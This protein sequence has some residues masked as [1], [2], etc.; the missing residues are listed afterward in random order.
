MRKVLGWAALLAVVALAQPGVAQAPAALPPAASADEAF[1]ARMNA[2]RAAYAKLAYADFAAKVASRMERAR[3]VADRYGEDSL[4]YA[5]ALQLAAGEHYDAKQ[6]TE[7]AAL[8]MRGLAI[9]RRLAGDTDSGTLNIVTTT[10]NALAKSGKAA[11][12]AQL[13]GEVLAAPGNDF[14]ARYADPKQ[15]RSIAAT[16]ENR[17]MGEAR[18]LHARLLIQLG[19]DPAAA[20]AS[21]RLAASASTAYLESSERGLDDE[22]RARFA[23]TVPWMA[24][25]ED[26]FGDFNRLYAN[27]LWSSGKR[28]AATLDE[29]LRLTQAVTGGAAS[30]AV[31]RAAAARYASDAGVGPLL[32]ERD[33][34]TAERNRLLQQTDTPIPVA[35]KEALWARILPLDRRIEEVEARI[36]AAA[37][38]FFAYMHP[39]PLDRAAATRLMGAGEAAL[40]II[41]DPLGTQ[42]LLID[43]NGLEW[44]RGTLAEADL[45][46]KV[47]RL[48]WNAG[49]NV[50]ASPAEE[51]A[52]GDPA[53]FDRATAH[54]LY[55]ELIAP[56]AARLVGKHSLTIVATGALTSMPFAM[57]VAAPPTGSD[58]DPA[59]LRATAW[60]GQRYA[61]TQLPSLQSLQLMRAAER[62]GAGA[63]RRFLGYGNPVLG[64]EAETRGMTGAAH[65]RSGATGGSVTTSEGADGVRLADVATLRSLANLP[66]TARELAAMAQAFPGAATVRLRGDATEA[67]LKDEPLT[68]LAVLAFST[69]GLLAGEGSMVR[70]NETG[71]VLTPPAQATRRDDG[72]LTATEVAMLRTD[73]DWVILSACNTAAGDGSYGAEGLSGLARAFFFAGAKSLLVSNWPVRD[74][75]AAVL[76]VKTV[77]LRRAHP[78]W[79][80]AQALQA[81]EQAIR[82]D[83][84]ADGDG[85]A[86]AH[87]NAWA[88]FTLVGDPAR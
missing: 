71:L 41:P 58:A 42:L 86:W 40:L 43:A 72:L 70:V 38:A 57:L 29:V 16:A 80:R 84:G 81:A 82:D 46:A 85:A 39:L 27:A 2:N 9:R 67:R 51:E 63:G 55:R 64:G 28:D 83:T 47:R 79:T 73:A 87:P 4:Q 32:A 60:L 11:E 18:A 48:L 17:P 50:D 5:D 52:W 25:G 23:E 37:P 49:A 12:A 53:A 14:S 7:E 21:A 59:A 78:D 13:L 68:G 22:Q 56:F 20:V 8:R 35:E 74:D 19:R 76:T 10:A 15:R 33:A 1:K 75:V 61:L 62:A 31:A 3:I 26:R 6:W 36:T 45:N 24:T 77:S 30:R 54:A 88:P 66:G 44:H 69:H 34:V 65:R